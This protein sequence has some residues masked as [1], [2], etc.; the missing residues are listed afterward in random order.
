[1]R[2]AYL[3]AMSD[4]AHERLAE[5]IAT[6]DPMAALDSLM[7]IRRLNKAK[8]SPGVAIMALV[9]GNRKME[10]AR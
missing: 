10:V 4:T 1:M 9:N 6:A 3:N 7:E 8:R 2:T 5:A